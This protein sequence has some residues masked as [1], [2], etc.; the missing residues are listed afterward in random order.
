MTTTERPTDPPQALPEDLPFDGPILMVGEH[1]YQIDDLPEGSRRLIQAI[2]DA[3]EQA[4]QLKRQINYIEIARRA[5]IQELLTS[6]PAQ[7]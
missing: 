3:E 5:L 7:N 4:L 2:R 6:L 1:S